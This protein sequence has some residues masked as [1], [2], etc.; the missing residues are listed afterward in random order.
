[1][2]S[3]LVVANGHRLNYHHLLT[4]LEASWPISSRNHPFRLV[5]SQVLHLLFF[6]LVNLQ[7]LELLSW[8]KVKHSYVVALMAIWI[9]QSCD[10]LIAPKS[11]SSL[12]AEGPPMIPFQMQASLT[13]ADPDLYSEV[14]R[15]SLICS[16]KSTI[17]TCR[18]Q[19]SLFPLVSFFQWSEKSHA[20]GFRPLPRR[21]LL[22]SGVLHIFSLVLNVVSQFYLESLIDLLLLSQVQLFYYLSSKHLVIVLF[23]EHQFLKYLY[24]SY[25]RALF[26]LVS[27]L[28]L[29]CELALQT[30]F[31]FLLLSLTFS[32]D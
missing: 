7:T 12:L 2:V 16:L 10:R 13:L 15:Q 14:F 29:S 9:T 4:C 3:R 19:S 23:S 18:N 5:I 6:A 1:M 32:L 28:R 11:A 27:V 22:V 17:L 24:L 20:V 21:F 31:Y 8:L 26:E 25:S 30:F